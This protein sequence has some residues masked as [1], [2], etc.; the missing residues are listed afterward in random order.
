LLFIQAPLFAWFKPDPGLLWGKIIWS[1]KLFQPLLTRWFG[2]SFDWLQVE[3]TSWCNAR[4]AYCP[5]TV[6]RHA[7]ESRHLSLET[8]RH[9]EPDLKRA[10]LV[11]LQG[12]G[13]PFLNPDFFT[14]VT[15]AKKQGCRV[16]T[17]TNGTLLSK[18]LTA[19]IVESGMDVIAFSLAGIGPTHD[20]WRPG[21]PFAQVL[22]AMLG[23]QE[24]KRR[25]GKNTPEVH[26]A[27]LLLRSGLRDLEKLP[28]ALRGLEISQVVVSTLDLVASPELEVEALASSSPQEYA[29]LSAKLA[30]VTARCAR[31]GLTLHYPR[32]HSSPGTISC[33]ENILRALVVS[34][35]GNISPCVFTNVP[36]T[37]VSHSYQGRQYL[38]LHLS[39]GNVLDQSLWDIW[40]RPEYIAFRRFFQ[41]AGR[42]SPCQHCHKLNRPL[43]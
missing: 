6:Y 32:P 34:A 5:H 1:F 36:A 37:G 21:A 7:W 41:P 18:S 22:E 40:R 11:Y 35:D 30:E 17:T 33:P 26:V 4:C 39:F 14:F 3:V 23:L 16:G 24:Y 8:F 31:Q 20:T 10:N 29:E 27:Y 28:E 19:Q 38:L 9:L 42:A 12:W 2:R 13:E 15:L 25:I 43:G